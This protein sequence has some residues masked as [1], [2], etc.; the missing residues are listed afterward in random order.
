[1]YI[2]I[3]N[4][5]YIMEYYSTIKKKEVLSSTIWMELE[6][7]ILQYIHVSSH[8]NACLKFM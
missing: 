3:W 4:S 5:T 7:L 1:M 2:Y 8:H 6:G